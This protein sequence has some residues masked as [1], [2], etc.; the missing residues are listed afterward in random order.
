M[1]R[2]T[3]AGSIESQKNLVK[4]PQLG[5]N[6]SL[7]TNYQTFAERFKKTAKVSSSKEDIVFFLCVK[8]SKYIYT[9]LIIIN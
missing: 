3:A 5:P 4:K 7:I 1:Q 2:Y 8:G 9:K 6:V